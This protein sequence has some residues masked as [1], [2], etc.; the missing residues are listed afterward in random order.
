MVTAVAFQ[1][2]Q[3]GDN[4]DADGYLNQ[5]AADPEVGKHIYCTSGE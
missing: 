1:M 3:I 4:Q 2:I 5:L